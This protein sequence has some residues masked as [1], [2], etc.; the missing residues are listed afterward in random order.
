MVKKM[1]SEVAKHVLDVAQ[2][3]IAVVENNIAVSGTPANQTTTITA[4]ETNNIANPN[5]TCMNSIEDSMVAISKNTSTSEEGMHTPSSEDHNNNN[6]ATDHVQCLHSDL[7]LQDATKTDT[8]ADVSFE[9]TPFISSQLSTPIIMSHATPSTVSVDPVDPEVGISINDDMDI[10]KLMLNRT[11]RQLVEAEEKAKAAAAPPAAPP[12]KSYPNRRNKNSTVPPKS[13]L[14]KKSNQRGVTG[15]KNK[16]AELVEIGCLRAEVVVLAAAVNNLQETVVEQGRRIEQ[17]STEDR[18]KKD[19]SGGDFDSKLESL[20][21]R[22]LGFYN[23]HDEKCESRKKE[24]LLSV[25]NDTAAISEKAE[26]ARKEAQSAA[27]A[28]ISNT[29][30]VEIT[31]KLD[32]VD[33]KVGICEKKCKDI[34]QTLNSFAD[35]T[36]FTTAQSKS[37]GKNGPAAAVWSGIEQPANNL[38]GSEQPK[39]PHTPEPMREDLN[40]EESPPAVPKDPH[41]KDSPGATRRP[42]LRKSILFMDSN[43]AFLDPEMLWKNLTLIPCGTTHILRDKLRDAC[44]NDYEI[45]FI[46]T[47]VNNIDT[48]DGEVVAKDIIDIVQK[49]RHHHPSIKVIVSEITPRQVFRDDEVVK[50]NELLRSTLKTTENVTMAFHSNLRNDQWSFHKKNDDKHFSRISIS[51]FASNIKNAFRACLGIPPNPNR[52]KKLR[53]I[54]MKTLRDNFNDRNQYTPRRDKQEDGLQNSNNQHLNN[55]NRKQDNVYPSNRQNYDNVNNR[56]QNYDNVNNRNQN[57]DKNY[58]SGNNGRDGEPQS[59]KNALMQLLSQF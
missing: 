14:K 15:K 48:E 22:I 27:S 18:L 52:K 25:K 36:P 30:A 9:S 44:L 56:N 24:V 11:F 19:S 1:D 37:A 35:T 6:S 32:T 55:F 5:N 42:H 21:T 47:G 31:K 41:I 54:K 58:N 16:E 7:M 43:L 8:E 26:S 59:L 46:H 20:E 23:D 29:N 38:G 3:N 2:D 49:L 40:V 39:R 57:G 4:G 17:L 51:M 28:I 10:D 13:P 45:V 33:A 12:S 34:E 53:G 50:C